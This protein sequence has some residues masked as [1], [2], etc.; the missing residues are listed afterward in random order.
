MIFKKHYDSFL[1]GIFWKKIILIYE[2]FRFNIA[3]I[4]FIS[5]LYF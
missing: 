5:K 4:Y 3:F 2:K 1:I